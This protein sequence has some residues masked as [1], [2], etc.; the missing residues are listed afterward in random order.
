MTRYSDRFHQKTSQS[1]KSR[2]H[3]AGTRHRKW[4]AEA[5]LQLLQH[6]PEYRLNQDPLTVQLMQ[7]LLFD[8]DDDELQRDFTE[9][10]NAHQL[11]FLNSGDAFWGNY[12]LPGNLNY[13]SDF[14]NLGQM[15]TGDAIGLLIS[16]SPGNVGVLGP[17]RSGKTSLLMNMFIANPHLLQN[18]RVIAFVKKPELRHLITV[19][20]LMS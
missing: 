18:S 17:T 5:I 13:P 7:L 15:P 11:A 4:S 8:P 14:V 9:R 19:S 10:V 1:P 2:K 6:H 3:S 12:P 20:E 16:Q